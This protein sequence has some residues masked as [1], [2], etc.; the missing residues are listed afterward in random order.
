MIIGN[1]SAGKSSFINWYLGD[2]VQ[3]TKVSIETIEINLVMHGRQNSELNGYN[4]MKQLP[5][6][7]DLY[8]K[9]AKQERFPGLLSSLSLKT[10]T[11]TQ[12]DFEQIVFIDTP[13]L[14]DGGLK[15]KFNVEEVYKWFARHCDLVCV[16]LDPIGQALCQKT[17]NL[18]AELV[19]QRRSAE[20][21]FYMTK[22][23]MFDS[24][25]DRTKCMC[26]I[27]QALSASIPPM[28]GFEMPLIYLPGSTRHSMSSSQI[29]HNQINQL[30]ELISKRLE[31]KVQNNLATFK[32][33]IQLLRRSIRSL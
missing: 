27:T 26:Q 16:F 12:R 23:D 24:E 18:V 13:G 28:H 32:N 10:S 20:V 22:G 7:R 2:K 21:R 17:N 9:E 3:S 4:L 31:I 5:F 6:M 8:N 30:T 14:A 29:V 1:H 15:Y 33:D 11:S 19:K 25:S